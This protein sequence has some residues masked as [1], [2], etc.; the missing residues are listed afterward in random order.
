MRQ[1]RLGAW[2]FAAM[3]IVIGC[4]RIPRGEPTGRPVIIDTPAAAHGQVVYMRHCYQCHQT[5]EGGLGPA[6]PA[7]PVPKSVVRLQVRAG[8]GAMPSFSERQ[9][10]ETEF[11]ALY[12]YLMA[13]WRS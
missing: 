11:D 4:V 12:E 8:L 6:L 3:L 13:G 7:V 5:G 10:S 9:I 1:I 2:L